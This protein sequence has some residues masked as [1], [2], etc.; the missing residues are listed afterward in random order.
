MSRYIV[1]LNG[2]PVAWSAHKQ[3]IIALSTAEAEYI[4]LTNVV[5]EL[6][7]LQLL[8]GELY[9]PPPLPIPILCDN[10]AAIALASNGKF[11]LRTKH[12]DLQ[13]HFVHL[14]AKDGT[15]KLLYCLT[16][17]NVAVISHIST[18][19]VRTSESRSSPVRSSDLL[20]I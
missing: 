20:L 7:Y 1:L 6:L 3:P 2:G 14:H 5:Q 9:D 19:L 4:A 10:Q 13:Y 18:L 17:N 11:Q 15:F 8:I 16:D 12:I